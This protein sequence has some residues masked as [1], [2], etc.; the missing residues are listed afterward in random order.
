MFLNQNFNRF[1]LSLFVCSLFITNSALYADDAEAQTELEKAKAEYAEGDFNAAAAAYKAAELYADSPAIK[2]KALENAA[3]A[4]GKAGLK[5]KQFKCLESLVDG[6]PD[7]IDFEKIITQE[8]KI[9]NEFT[10]GHRDISLSWMPWIKDKNRAPE[11]YEALIRQAPFAKFA[12]ELKFRLGRMYIEEGKNKQALVTLRKLIKQHPKAKE[13]KYAR[14]ELAN[15]LVQLANKAG[16]GDGSYAREAEEVLKETLKLYPKDPET[17]WIKE[18]IKETDDVRAER[19]FKLA[20][21]YKSRKNPEAAKRYFNDLIARFPDSDYVDAAEKQ[22]TELDKNYKPREI[23]KSKDEYPYPLSEMNDEREVILIAPEASGGKWLLPIEDLDLDSVNA[24]SEY[25]AKKK[26]EE[27][28]RRRAEARR[29]AELEAR[30]A[31]REKL[32][33]EKKA[34]QKADEEEKARKQK[35]EEDQRRKEAEEKAK[36]LEED[37]KKLAKEKE[38]EEAERKRKEKEA[39]EEAARKK[40]EEENL[41]KK[42]TVPDVETPKEIKKEISEQDESSNK[43]TY[44]VLI[45][46]AI[47][48]IVG[49][50]IYFAKRKKQV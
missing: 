17:V 39:A 33:A 27:E 40:A 30:K 13:A 26:A 4:Y 12:P 42:D 20:K 3:D 44:L 2:M 16:D 8:Y 37:A 29:K 9:G 22:L 49:G 35:E 10:K 23:E 38:A 32:E 46:L 47:L 18:S 48:A 7:R 25:L 5:F 50:I 31:A 28:A 45:I 43:V 19:L 24:D 1:F 14:F 21:F 11:I 41:K 15:A 34:K 36:K 6:F